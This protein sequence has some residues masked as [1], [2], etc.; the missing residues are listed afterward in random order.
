MCT[1]HALQKLKEWLILVILQ[2]MPL[3]IGKVPQST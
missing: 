2:A 1:Q 3:S